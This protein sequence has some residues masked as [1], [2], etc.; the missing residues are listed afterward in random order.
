MTVNHDVAGS[1]PAGGAR[2][3]A[4]AIASAFFN[5]VFRNRNEIFLAEVKCVSC[6][7][8]ALF[9]HFVLEP[10]IQIGKLLKY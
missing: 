4:L 5:D 6:V 10:V 7:K 3:K 2:E 9:R 1:S 8:R